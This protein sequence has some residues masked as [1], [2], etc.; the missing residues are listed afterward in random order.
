MTREMNVR[1]V[2]EP[3]FRPV[4]SAPDGMDSHPGPWQG[5]AA[6]LFVGLREQP[7]NLADVP[8]DRVSQRT[9][10]IWCGAIEIDGSDSLPTWSADGRKPLGRVVSS[11][12]P[13]GDMIEEAPAGA[14]EGRAQERLEG[15]VPLPPVRPPQVLAAQAKVLVTLAHGDLREPKRNELAARVAFQCEVI[16]VDRPQIDVLRVRVVCLSG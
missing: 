10:E 12:R 8:A 16:G 15:R 4:S 5:V 7:V 11:G 1:E 2:W 14:A 3:G 6:Q 9:P 13:T